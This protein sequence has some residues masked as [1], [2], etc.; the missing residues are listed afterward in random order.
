MRSYM[1][2]TM[3]GYLDDRQLRAHKTRNALHSLA[4]LTGMA[5]ILGL[6]GWLIWG[7]DIAIG[8]LAGLALGV[9]LRPKIS[10]DTVMNLYGAQRIPPG[11]APPI[12][13]I[14]DHLAQRGGLPAVPR[15]YYLPSST[16]NAFAVGTRRD[17]AICVTDGLL[18]TMGPREVAGVLA[19][20][21]SH[22]RNDDL[23]IMALADLL[24]R[25]TAIMSYAG[26]FLLLLNIPLFLAGVA[27]IPWP[28]VILLTLAPTLGSLLQLGLSRNREYEAD[29]DAAGL[30]G[31]PAGLAAALGKLERYQG[32]FWEEIIMPGRRI[33]EPSLL[34]THPPTEER[35]RRL[36]ALS[37]LPQ[38]GFV[39]P[40]FHPGSLAGEFTAPVGRPRWRLSGRWY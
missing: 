37:A 15:L 22:I 35:V 5:G 16:L 36:M 30:T 13:T 11:V 17:A 21:I 6:C 19:H 7:P 2:S 31:D 29:L 24:T 14:L 9:L 34:R 23:R 40:E 27:V 8:V 39:L 4:L 12:S 25:F 26:M 20:E 32:R 38:P 3:T 18:R 33:P 28:G 10:P 1:K